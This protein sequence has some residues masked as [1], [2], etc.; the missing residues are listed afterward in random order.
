[1]VITVGFVAL[2]LSDAEP[3]ALKNSRACTSLPD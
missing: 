3:R 1:M 2:D